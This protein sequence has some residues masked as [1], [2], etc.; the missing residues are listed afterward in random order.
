[1]KP[2]ILKLAVIVF[3]MACAMPIFLSSVKSSTDLDEDYPTAAP[4]DPAK[5]QKL[6]E[7]WEARYK[8]NG[9][10]ENMVLPLKWSKGLSDEF[11]QAAGYTKINLIE[12][13]IFVEAVGL[14]KEKD[15][16]FWMIDDK[17]GEGRSIMPEPTDLML[18]V[19]TL[20]HQGKGASLE[21]NLGPEAFASFEPDLFIISQAGKDPSESRVLI[22]YMSLYLSLYRSAQKGQFG[23]LE[24]MEP[25]PLP[26][27]KEL[28]VWDRIVNALSP[29]ASA[30]F[31]EGP[32]SPPIESIIAQGK[33]LFT[34][35]TFAGN[36]RTCA[37]CHPIA[38]NFTIDPAFHRDPASERS[39]LHRGARSGQSGSVREASVDETGRIDSGKC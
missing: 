9:G 31:S 24:G 28:S 20:K 30:Q 14:S 32:I 34:R 3:L 36:G 10:D 2:N 12:G 33:V 35:E 21:V 38:N 22:G 7:K 17:P 25:R 23:V 27:E 8:K 13:K 18:R 5:L 6:Y 11:T 1:M 39:S 19:G 29:T 4:G 26:S 37:S 16:D 15:W